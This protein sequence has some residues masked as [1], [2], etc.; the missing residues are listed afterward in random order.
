MQL[1]KDLGHNL[2][3]QMKQHGIGEHTVVAL[4]GQVELKQALLQ[5]LKAAMA[6]RVRRSTLGT[7]QTDGA[8]TCI[9]P[10]S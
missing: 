8:M 10:A 7:L 2:T 9:D 3:E 4:R 6:A 5:Q 1:T